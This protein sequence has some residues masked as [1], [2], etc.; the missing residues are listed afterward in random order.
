L[1]YFDDREAN[2]GCLVEQRREGSFI[3]KDFDSVGQV[4][5]IHRQFVIGKAARG[6]PVSDRPNLASHLYQSEKGFTGGYLV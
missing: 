4:F 6:R 5:A 2:S 1:P 3:L